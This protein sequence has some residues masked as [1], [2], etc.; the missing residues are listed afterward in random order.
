MM[1]DTTDESSKMMDLEHVTLYRNNFA[2]YEH[3]G[4]G[5]TLNVRVPKAEKALAM[6]TF[7]VQQC[8]PGT[9]PMMVDY[10]EETLEQQE[11]RLYAFD[12]GAGKPL[13]DFLSSCIGTA[14]SLDMGDGTVC[15]GH[16]MSVEKTQQVLPGSDGEHHVEKKS[17]T[18]QVYEQ[19]GNVRTIRE[20]MD[21]KIEDEYLQSQLALALRA[22]LQKAKPVP[23]GTSDKETIRVSLYDSPTDQ[24]KGTGKGAEEIRVSYVGK[25]EEWKCSYRMEVPKDDDNGKADAPV[26]LEYV[27]LQ[28][29][30]KVRNHSN[31]DWNDVKLSLVANELELMGTKQSL[32]KP[33]SSSVRGAKAAHTH[34]GQSIFVKTLT[35]KVRIDEYVL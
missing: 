17:T 5:R 14:I 27:D 8:P 18:I 21:V 3:R 20:V 7:S 30:G 29:L 19:G 23:P 31:N 10:T 22:S 1:N 13:G 12:M 15:R 2:Y 24:R 34:G 33:T 25:S 35:G 6:D 28:L 9:V 11:P 32:V 4:W 16:L 26:M